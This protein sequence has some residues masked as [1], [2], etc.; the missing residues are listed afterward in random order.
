MD[1]L[2]LKVQENGSRNLNLQCLKQRT[3]K[4][5]EEINEE[6]FGKVYAEFRKGIENCV[7][8]EGNYVK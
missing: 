7:E 4:A 3:R 1:F 8:N 6:I 5:I 2:K